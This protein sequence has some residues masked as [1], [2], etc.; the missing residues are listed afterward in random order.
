MKQKIHDAI[1]GFVVGDAI[2]V[3]YEFKTR[4]LFN[5]TDMRASTDADFHFALPLGTWSDDT[6]LMLCVLD[7]LSNFG[8]QNANQKM[9]EVF[10]NNAVAWAKSGKFTK[11]R[12]NAPCFSY[13]RVAYTASP[14][15][16]LMGI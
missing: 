15:A 8:T 4:G 7:A 5:C 1:M 3:P 14:L 9:F 13:E 10:R 11:M 6:S 12:R 16:M 2:G